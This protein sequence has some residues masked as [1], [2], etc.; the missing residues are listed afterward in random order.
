M[1]R[2]VLKDSQ[3]EIRNQRVRLFGFG[4][5]LNSR[6]LRLLACCL[7]TL[8]VGCGGSGDYVEVSG[9]VTYEDGSV[10]PIRGMQVIFNPQVNSTEGRAGRSKRPRAARAAVNEKDGTF[11]TATTY[12]YGD[13][14][15][16]GKYIVTLQ[17]AERKLPPAY[18]SLDT[19]PFHADTKDS[20]F[21]FLVKKP[22]SGSR[23]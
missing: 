17:D 16:A 3:S 8:L 7:L 10:I 22:S 6:C 21:T 12:T 4:L 11:D 1:E 23:Y 19:T 2:T 13:G 15:P 20:P 9:K 18:A 14:L 5:P